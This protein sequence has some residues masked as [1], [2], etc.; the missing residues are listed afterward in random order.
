MPLKP[1]IYI[2]SLLSK[3]YCIGGVGVAKDVIFQEILPISALKTVDFV[4]YTKLE[5]IP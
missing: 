5:G 1:S 4:I 3:D 2:F